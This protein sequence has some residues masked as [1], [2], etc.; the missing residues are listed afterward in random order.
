MTSSGSDPLP[1]WK[2]EKA[3]VITA[4]KKVLVADDSPVYRHLVSQCLREWGF[5]V[6]LA[7][8]G[9]EA[10]KII[11]QPASPTLVI[12]DW[13]MPELNGVELCRKIRE[14]SSAPEYV[15]TILLTSKDEKRDLLTAMAGGA[16]DYLVKPF[17][18]QELRARLSVGERICTMQREL[19]D[20]RDELR[21]A[22]M[23][24]GL[25]ELL[26]H[27]EITESLRRELVRSQRDNKPVSV[28]MADIDHFKAVND[29][30]GHQAGDEV[31]KEIARRLR[32][33]V[34]TYDSVG[35]YGGEEFMMVLPGC[36]LSSAF[37]RADEFRA[38]VSGRPI[39]TG[40]GPRTVT[41]S[42]GVAATNGQS[43]DNAATLIR[44]A[45]LGL[46]QAKQNGRNRVEQVDAAGPVMVQHARTSP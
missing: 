20:A 45:D 14:R 6:V 46:Y 40:V 10:W 1:A 30:L 28:I 13:V 36:S 35:R 11:N 33:A 32:M 27:S 37:S 38:S 22:A 15:Y 12:T 18:E 44:L 2:A 8:D 43:K 24:D 4:R 16:D 31:L 5:E 41:L 26:N 19:L 21:R 23:H 7:N 39:H 42:V 25:T 17:D 29:E 9:R 34:R 3:A